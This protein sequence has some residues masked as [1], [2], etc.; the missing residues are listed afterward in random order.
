MSG[1]KWTGREWRRLAEWGASFA[2]FGVLVFAGVK[3]IGLGLTVL[4]FVVLGA[5]L[6]WGFWVA[7]LILAGAELFGV[8]PTL[9]VVAGLVVAWGCGFLCLGLALARGGRK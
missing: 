4:A 3:L 7:V 8:W 6:T 2:L 1:R 5:L 9:L